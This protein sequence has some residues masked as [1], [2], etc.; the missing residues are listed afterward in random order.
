MTLRELMT[1]I[2]NQ[3]DHL[4]TVRSNGFPEGW[5]GVPFSLERVHHGLY[6]VGVAFAEDQTITLLFTAAPSPT[7]DPLDAELR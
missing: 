1:A 3:E 4:W 5:P 6:R 2:A 7:A